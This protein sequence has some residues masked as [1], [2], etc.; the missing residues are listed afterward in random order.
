LQA[1]PF[2]GPFI[3]GGQR[4]VLACAIVC[5]L[6]SSIIVDALN[7]IGDGVVIPTTA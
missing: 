1:L 2:Y 4:D 7:A 3:V 5:R 6:S